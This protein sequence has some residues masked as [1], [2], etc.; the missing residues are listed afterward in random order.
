MDA[1]VV[2]GCVVDAGGN[3][4]AGGAY[5]AGDAIQFRG[6]SLTLSGTPADGDSF[7]LGAS[8]P[9][10]VFATA[11]KIAGLVAGYGRTAAQ[12]AQD[13]TA[14]Y[15]TLQS[16]DTAMSH[17]S[18]VRGGVGA[19]LNVLDDASTQLQSR[20][21]QLQQS[22]SD[23]REVD[24]T[25]ATAQMSQTQTVLQAAQQSYLKVQGLSLFD[26]MN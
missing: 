12:S 11:Q 10:S 9:Q 18:N 5:K 14:L 24:Y 13:Q 17:L 25:A 19:R 20:S 1:R 4:V 26:Y 6:V 3:A 2:L 15:S 23:L 22:L 7:T 16:L 21:A 8:Q